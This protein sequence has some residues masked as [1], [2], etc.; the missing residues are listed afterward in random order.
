MLNLGPDHVVEQTVIEEISLKRSHARE[1]LLIHFS[2]RARRSSSVMG[3]PSSD[4]SNAL[5]DNPIQT[6]PC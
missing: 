5:S 3:F 4:I 2:K 6:H 1:I